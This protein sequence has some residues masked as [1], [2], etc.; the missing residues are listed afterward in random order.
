MSVVS[1]ADYKEKVTYLKQPRSF[2]GSLIY[3]SLQGQ[4]IG[5]QN[6]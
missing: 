3:H 2:N 6:F 1:K 5:V 4:L